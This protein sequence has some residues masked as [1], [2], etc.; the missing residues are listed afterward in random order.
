[1][2]AI[3]TGRKTALTQLSSR[4]K[5]EANVKTMTEQQRLENLR[6]QEKTE[7]EACARSSEKM[8]ELQWGKRQACEEESTQTELK[9]KV[10]LS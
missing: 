6:R 4:S 2:T 9:E 3:S 1:M 8:E 5:E 7:R 10:P